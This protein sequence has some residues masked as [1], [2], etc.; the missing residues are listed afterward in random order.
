MEPAHPTREERVPVEIPRGE[1]R[2]GFVAAV[3]ENHGRSDTEAPIA[4]DRCHVGAG[5]AVVDEALVDGANTSG[6][7]AFGDEVA[8]GV[9][10]HGRDDCG[11]HAEAVRQVGGHVELAAAD[12]DAALGRFAE[13]DD[14]RI[15]PVHQRAQGD[16]VQGAFRGDD[17]LSHE[18][19]QSR[20]G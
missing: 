14:A 17:Q 3:V 8:D 12:V 1:A 15:E 7:D 16:Q 11:V 13:G 2:G 19:L 20:T 6:P 5:D 4:E 18:L 9:V 10:H